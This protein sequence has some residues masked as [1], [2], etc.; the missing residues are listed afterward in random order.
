MTIRFKG[1]RSTC[2]C[3]C[4]PAHHFLVSPSLSSRFLLAKSGVELV[5]NFT[6]HHRI[7]PWKLE[8]R[9]LLPSSGR[10]TP[11]CINPLTNLANLPGTEKTPRSTEITSHRNAQQPTA[12][13]LIH[14]QPVGLRGRDGLTPAL[15]VA[16]G[17]PGIKTT[18]LPRIPP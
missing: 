2:P 15:H 4:T 13:H 10:T 8:S 1:G 9:R 6:C 5:Y 16:C 12:S 7:L 17:D 11:P 3:P 18:P 14:S